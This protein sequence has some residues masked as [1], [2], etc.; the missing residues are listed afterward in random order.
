MW[1]NWHIKTQ[2]VFSVTA[3]VW[4]PWTSLSINLV[5]K[6]YDISM[7]IY[8]EPKSEQDQN[9]DTKG[10]MILEVLRSHYLLFSIFTG[11]IG[12]YIAALKF[13][14]LIHRTRPTLRFSVQHSSHRGGGGDLFTSMSVFTFH[15][16][17]INIERKTE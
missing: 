9:Q 2:F 12:V 17:K 3:V 13:P 7:S 6:N 4:L 8:N 10:R 1:R 16:R 5:L 11:V 15:L 14:S